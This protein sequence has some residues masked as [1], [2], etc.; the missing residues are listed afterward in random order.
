MFE[1][2]TEYAWC[3]RVRGGAYGF[4]LPM[5]PVRSENGETVCRVEYATEAQVKALAAEMKS[6]GCELLLALKQLPA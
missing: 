5:E 4:S 6:R 3:L 2:T 1:D